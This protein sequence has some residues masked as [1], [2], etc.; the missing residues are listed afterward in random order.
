MT[1][2][3]SFHYGTVLV[4][5]ISTN[6]IINSLF[7]PQPRSPPSLSLSE[8]LHMSMCMHMT[9][10]PIPTLKE[11]LKELSKVEKWFMLGIFLDVPVDQL[12]K[13]ES[14]HQQRDLER[15]MIDMLKYWLNNNVS[16][17][18]KDVV[19]ALEQ[20]DQLVL[21]ATVKQKYLCGDKG[22]GDFDIHL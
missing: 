14:S 11:L 3:F 19:R 7:L 15:C 20:I 4:C 10:L 22:E 6:K 1:P 17:S 8:C 21:A 18:W 9:D 12:E 16:A 2:T 5:L 13:I